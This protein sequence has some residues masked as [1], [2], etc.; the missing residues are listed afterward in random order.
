MK[1]SSQIDPPRWIENLLRSF[2]DEEVAESVIGDIT[3]KFDR[4]VELGHRRRATLLYIL[5]GLALLRL[6]GFVKRRTVRHSNNFGMVGNYFLVAIRNLKKEKLYWT[7][8]V[9][10]LAIGLASVLVIYAYVRFELSYD[11]FHE[12]HEKIFR[13]TSEFE[14]DGARVRSARC[15]DRISDFLTQNVPGITS[16]VKVLP[17]NGFVSSDPQTKIREGAFCHVDSSFFSMFSFHAVDGALP[18]SLDA[19]FNLVITERAAER[20]FGTMNVI[21]RQLV[22]EDEVSKET[23]NIVAV[24]NNF[25]QNSHFA[26]DFVAPLSSLSNHPYYNDG[27]PPIYIYTMMDAALPVAEVDSRVKSAIALS[28]PEFLKESNRFRSGGGLLFSV[29]ALTDIHLFSQLQGE[30]EANSQYIYLQV[31]AALALFILFIACINFINLATAQA[32]K[33]SREVGVR[34]VFGG[35]RLQLIFQ[36]LTETLVHVLIAFGMS[37]MFA[38]LALRFILFSVIGKDLSIFT[39]FDVTTILFAIAFILTVSF[40]AGVYPSVYL[41]KLRPAAVLKG[42]ALKQGGEFFRRG[43]VTF[44][45]VISCLLVTGTIIITRQVK[46]FK[47]LDLGFDKEQVMAIALTDRYAAMNY[48]VL[49]DRL[50][51]ESFVMSTGLSSTVPGRERFY[52]WDIVPEG[53]EKDMPINIKTLGVD[54]GF[55]DTY[56]LRFID[57]RNFSR[58]ITTDQT[59]AFIINEAAAKMLGW[60]DPVGKEIQL[61]AYIGKREV[62][63]G[64]VIGFVK[65]FNF[66]SLHSRVDPLLIYINKHMYF[67]DNLSVRLKPGDVG[68]SMVQIENIW[69]E[70]HPERPI[71]YLFIDEDLDRLYQAEAKFGSI[72][73]S[74]SFIAIFI[75]AL[76]IFALSSYMAS[77]RAKEMG[78]RKVFGASSIGLLLLQYRQYFAVVII[79]NAIT[80][81][82]CT[83]GALEWFSTMPYHI[84]LDSGIFIATF[85]GS[86]LVTL[87]II[88][89]HTSRVAIANPVNVIRNE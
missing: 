27:Y 45:I 63:K 41:S 43:L 89:F 1:A 42:V 52:G 69:R 60:Q 78:I 26:F 36:F 74:I 7:M 25:P 24:I 67:A 34:K 83:Y 28:Q 21:G 49:S 47:T 80:I 62:R 16:V 29:Q 15:D 2:L 57:G 85:L 77:R 5:E 54:E 48:Q 17:L 56:K 18:N 38:E 66:E 88:T 76:G 30:W 73:S 44:Q 61:T 14:D 84:S 79:A 35:L 23:Y 10:G 12:N 68:E 70:F 13:I 31:F 39:L 82:L 40:S 64:K 59:E 4:R 22:F 87:M 50:M 3:E 20:Y 46:H 72:L 81:P 9:A 37:L 19:P 75:S 8:S 51:R 58:V 55:A 53:R 71:E 11:R 65:D 33:R 32:I 6:V 86:L